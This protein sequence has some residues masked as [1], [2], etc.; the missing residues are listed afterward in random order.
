MSPED[1]FWADKNLRQ[2]DLQERFIKDF[3]KLVNEAHFYKLHVLVMM[4]SSLEESHESSNQFSWSSPGYASYYL[5]YMDAK[6]LGGE[7]FQEMVRGDAKYREVIAV[8]TGEKRKADE[9]AELKV[10]GRGSNSDIKRQRLRDEVRQEI[11]DKICELYSL[12][13]YLFFYRV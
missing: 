9:G 10:G 8:S 2:K 11:L 12:I 1:R 4:A 3:G 6:G 7:D 13:F 5:K